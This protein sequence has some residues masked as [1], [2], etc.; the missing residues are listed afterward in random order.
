VNLVTLVGE[1]F[2]EFGRDN[3]AA[4]VGWIA[5]NSDFHMGSIPSWFEDSR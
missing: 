5:D 1:R 4:A 3:A 2:A